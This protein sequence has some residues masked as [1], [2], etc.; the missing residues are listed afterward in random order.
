[1]EML[2]LEIS[3]ILLR[4]VGLGDLSTF[5]ILYDGFSI[6][7]SNGSSIKTFLDLI[8]FGCAYVLEADFL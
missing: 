4:I 1:M 8:D 2:I 3:N 7:I 6:F 5:E